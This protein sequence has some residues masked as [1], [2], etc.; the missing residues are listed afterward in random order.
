MG[1]VSMKT[2]LTLAFLM[3]AQPA[4]CLAQSAAKQACNVEVDVTD[5][6]PK[7]TNVR[8]AP[9]GDVIAALKNPT[10]DGWIL[11]HLTGQD[12]D[13]FEI[14]RAKLI[15]SNLPSGEKVLFQGNGY[16]H[17][18]VVGVSGM[19]NG[20]FIYRNHDVRTE[21]IDAHAAGDQKVDLLG[22]WG[23]FLQVHVKKG[24]GWT[25]QACTNMN[26]TCSRSIPQFRTELTP[27][28]SRLPTAS[29]C[30]MAQARWPHVLGDFRLGAPAAVFTKYL[31]LQWRGVFTAN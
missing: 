16:L 23:E 6:D 19:Q 11:V 2:S 8:A 24:T 14:D 13:W 1:T 27:R 18:S 9:S 28:D 15:D 29:C 21:L 10:S 3:I 30:F 26:T 31:A 25:T 4:A 22:C 20:G 12:G 5:T 7:G 17:K